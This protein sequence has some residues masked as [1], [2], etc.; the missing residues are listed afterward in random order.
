MQNK[1][2]LQ[3]NK[4]KQW[5]WNG[6]RF[7]FSQFLKLNRMQLAKNINIINKGLKM[8][9]EKRPSTATQASE[10]IQWILMNWIKYIRRFHCK[11][12]MLSIDNNNTNQLHNTHV[13]LT[14]GTFYQT[15]PSFLIYKSF[16][17]KIF[18]Q[19]S[20]ENFSDQY[21]I[22]NLFLTFIGYI[23]FNSSF[24]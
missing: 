8:G 4:N 16:S 23:F 11:W 20:L 14:G 19:D 10:Q 3:R 5:G 9:R 2:K 22:L 18:V 21:F 7:Y 1:K 24:W 13:S 15:L 17:I 6:F 12:L